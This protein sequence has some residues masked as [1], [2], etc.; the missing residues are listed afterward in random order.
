MK[1]LERKKGMHPRVTVAMQRS[2]HLRDY[3]N[4]NIDVGLSRDVAG[5]ETV[6]DVLKITENVVYREVKKL[7]KFVRK[8]VK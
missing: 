6:D 8:H 1:E 5:D 7:T 2:I 4:F 3:E